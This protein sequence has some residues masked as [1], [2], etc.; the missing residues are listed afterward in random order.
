[1][2]MISNGSIYHRAFIIQEEMIGGGIHAP[3]SEI[4]MFMKEL[5]GPDITLE[6]MERQV[7]E[8]ISQKYRKNTENL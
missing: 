3:V 6:E 2:I 1:M 8:K 5:N 7:K 4:R